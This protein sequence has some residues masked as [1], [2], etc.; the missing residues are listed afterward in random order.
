[1]HR[2]RTEETLLETAIAQKEEENNGEVGTW[3]RGKREV[4]GTE[5][6]KVRRATRR[7]L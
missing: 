1:M 4:I 2:Q 3:K 7:G 6:A 5:W